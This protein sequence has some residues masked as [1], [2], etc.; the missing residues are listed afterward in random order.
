MPIL[1]YV[2]KNSMTIILLGKQDR[3]IYSVYEILPVQTN[4]G[5]D[6]P[7][8]FFHEMVERIKKPIPNG[9][10]LGTMMPPFTMR[11]EEEFRTFI[12]ICGPRL[13]AWEINAYHKNKAESKKF[14]SED[15]RHALRTLEVL[16]NI[17]WLPHIV[18]VPPV[19]VVR[20][21]LDEAFF[22]L[23]E[24]KTRIEEIVGQIRRTGMLPKWGILLHGPA[25]TGKTSIAKVIARIL[26]MAIIQMDMS[27]LGDDPDEISGSS[28]IYQNAR[29]G[30][31]P[32]VCSVFA[33]LPPFCSLMK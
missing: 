11:T 12:D 31:L 24:V 3:N 16:M 28:R 6:I 15:K 23:E 10:E 18:N 19:D 20:R 21:L 2:V 17:D 22:G 32:R 14:S 9:V 26:C 25:G 27:S 30:M 29:P 5:K 33:P 1:N 7:L 4:S 8:E 13:P